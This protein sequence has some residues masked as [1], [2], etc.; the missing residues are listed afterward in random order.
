MGLEV[1]WD[2]LWTLSF[3]LSQLHGHGSWLVCEVAVRAGL[4]YSEEVHRLANKF[5]PKTRFFEVMVGVA[6]KMENSCLKLEFSRGQV[7]CPR[8]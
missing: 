5:Q 8:V 1:F 2:G 6:E 7:S 4:D 3:G